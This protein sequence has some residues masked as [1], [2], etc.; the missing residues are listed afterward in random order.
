MACRAGR[1]RESAVPREEAVDPSVLSST[2]TSTAH[3]SGRRV[4]ITMDD[5]NTHETPRYGV[6]QRNQLILEQ[7]AAR[8][9]QVM[10]FVCGKRIDSA[11]GAELLKAFD[12]AGHLL[13]N[14]SYF[15]RSY[16]GSANT[17]AMLASDM[18]QCEALLSRYR[19]FRR[20]FR[21]PY[22]KE[23]ETL[24]QR[25]AL[26]GVLR[27]QGYAN[28]SVT[29]DASDWAYDNRLMARLEADPAV[30]LAPFRA[31]YLAHML[32]RARYYD[33][34]ATTLTGYS[35]PHTLLLHH[36]LLN[37]LFIGDL[38][39][40]LQKEGF[41]IIAPETAYAD[42]VFA[43]DPPSLPAGESLIWALAN[44]DARLRTGLRYPAEDDVYEAAILSRL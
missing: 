18:G 40:A 36:S 6:E 44:S 28:G 1:A 5:P 14:H 35:V 39:D 25:D 10:L 2:S 8:H 31:A 32:D 9:V 27:A 4:A 23:G 37:A 12:D 13:A 19:G 29:I 22:L 17:A 20:R 16:N 34:L 26:R 43:L 42:P 3:A 30:D 11:R 38:I 21:F 7:L 41:R 24:Q 33:P 15:H